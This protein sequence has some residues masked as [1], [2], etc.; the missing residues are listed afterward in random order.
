[1]AVGDGGSGGDPADRAQKLSELL[2]KILRID[3]A[4]LPTYTIPLGN[5][6]ATD[7]DPNTRAEI[8]ASGLRNPWRL[9]FDRLTG[10][11]WLGDV[12]QNL[13]EEIDVQAANSTGGENYGW[14]CYEGTHVYSDTSQSV[15]CNGQ[16]QL[17]IYDYS[18]TDGSAVTGGYIYRGARY[19]NLVGQYL[20]ADFGSGHFWIS[21]PNG[22]SGWSTVKF[23]HQTGWPGNPSSFGQDLNGELYVADYAGGQSNK[24]VIY[25]VED[26]SGVNTTPTATSTATPTNTFVPTSTFVPTGP[27]A[28][29]K[30]R[31]NLPLIH[32]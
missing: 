5:P 1:M 23:A 18:H 13:Y 3:V 7:G 24:G 15:P 22:Q 26:Q 14:D 27:T 19:P 11:L 29:P 8:W 30:A 21:T 16:Y 2:G 6:Y 28:T 17:P 9:S 25:Q 20:F 12:G 32:K 10:D 31:V 4:G